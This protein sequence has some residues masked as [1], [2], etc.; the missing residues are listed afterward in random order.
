MGASKKA[1]HSSLIQLNWP[2]QLSGHSVIEIG[3]SGGLDSVVLLDLLC[4]ARDTCD[5]ELSAVHV[6]HG[7]SANADA[8]SEHCRHLCADN[9]IP[10]RIEHVN[11]APNG[12]GIE[13]AA[14]RARYAVYRQSRAQAVALA[15]HLDD[16][17]ETLLLQ[18]L[19][20]G[21]PHALA[22]MPVWR[23][24]TKQIALWR[25]LLA[26]TRD[27]LAAHAAAEGLRWV[28]DESNA[29]PRYRRNWLRHAISPLLAAQLPDYRQALQRCATQMADAAAMLDEL[30]A[31][32]LARCVQHGQLQLDALL[33]LS[34]PRQRQ[35]LLRWVELAGLG[36]PTPASVE[37]FRQQLLLAQADRQPAWALPNGTVYRYR[38]ALWPDPGQQYTL[39]NVTV[40]NS[41]RLEQPDWGGTLSWRRAA[42][43]LSDAMLAQGLTLRLP[44]PGSRLITAAGH[45]TLKQ[46]FQ[47]AGIPPF[48]RRR[49][50]GLYLTDGTLVA[51][52]S[53]TVDATL[54]V[55]GGWQPRWT[56]DHPL[57][58]QSID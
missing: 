46:L 42:Y 40:R 33:S 43:G 6:H 54:H 10:L 37:N 58:R 27:Q 9:N 23:P 34:A 51:L 56:L 2:A 28:D 25:P 21:G 15:Q 5:L 36:T 11:V 12:D 44:P 38:Q 47:E 17:A 48:L 35:L 49:W 45:K 16:Q 19:R 57:I 22:A 50:P 55:A 18:T 32:D 7:L 8:W 14:R 30:A 1:R 31:D 24:L 26:Y 53:V 20:G 39:P 41:D 52:P 29:D 4:A 3:L 13:S